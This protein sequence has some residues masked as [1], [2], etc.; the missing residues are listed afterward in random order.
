MPE[1]DLV[2]IG[3]GTGG[4]TAA[5]LFARSGKRVLLMERDRPGGDCLWS[6]C[7]PTK[8]LIECARRLHE[9][10]NSA[11]FGVIDGGVS[12]DFQEVRRHIAAS[13]AAA[14]RIDSPEAIAA[15]AV[16]LR[17]G[18]A[19]FLNAHTV[20]VD[21]QRISGASFVIAT[22]S[23]ASIPPIPG[24]L[25]SNPDTNS[26][27]L[28][29][30]SLPAS[31]AIIGGGPIGL[32]FGQAL[33]RLGVEVTIIESADRIAEKEEPKASEVLAAVLE[34]EGVRIITGAKIEN[35]VRAG[36][37]SVLRVR[38]RGGTAADE[39]ISAQRVLVATG[40]TARIEG[41]G[42]ERAGVRIENGHI[43]V[44]SVQRTSQPHIFAVGDVAA[45]GYK[46]THVAE[47]QGRLVSNYLTA[48]RIGRRFQRWSDRVVPR[49]TYTDPEVASIGI[50]SAEARKTLS[51]VK[52]WHL[53]LSEVDRA[54]VIGRTEGFIRIVT[55]RGW[56][57]WTPGLARLAGDEIVG[58]TIV[59]P[60]AGEL[61]M[62]IANAMRL[63]LPI[64]L[65]AL[66]MQA[67]PTLSLGVRQAAGLPF[68]R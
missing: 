32:E 55:A 2:V 49:V 43:I 59:A 50:S 63:R 47:A 56:M 66:Q 16:E 15:A 68:E 39:E 53:P 8:A 21:G 4:L 27:L 36:A 67:Y 13:Q 45:G 60:H 9:A 25:E 64:G 5:K 12:F 20:E 48:G 40:R 28:E 54:I 23:E 29:W 41:L 51:R 14:G 52:E 33:N 6:G 34:G 18:N 26:E 1:Y 3:A 62:P 65:L 58:A 37:R 22:G 57:R 30:E 7:V 11:K 31:L 61:L 38:R 19:T 24:L 42:L 35:V 17:T 44:D 46:F 10:R